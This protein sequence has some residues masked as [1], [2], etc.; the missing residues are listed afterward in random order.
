MIRVIDVGTVQLRVK[1]TLLYVTD[2]APVETYSHIVEL[3]NV[4]HTPNLA[5]ST[6][7]LENKGRRFRLREKKH[8]GAVQEKG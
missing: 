3:K 6:F 5:Y 1:K 7:G 8:V 2:G 4:L